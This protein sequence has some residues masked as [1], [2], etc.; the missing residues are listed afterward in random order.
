MSKCKPTSLTYSDKIATNICKS[1]SSFA[2]TKD[3]CHKAASP[4]SDR[5]IAPLTCDELKLMLL[6]PFLALP[7]FSTG[8]ET[9]KLEKKFAIKTTLTVGVDYSPIFFPGLP[10]QM[11]FTEID[12]LALAKFPS[13]AVVISSGSIRVEYIVRKRGDIY[14]IEPS[15]KSRNQPSELSVGSVN[16]QINTS[17]YG[18]CSGFAK[19]I[20]I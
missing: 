15:N 18:G 11:T 9:T 2:Y 10:S 20:I 8:M 17:A 7:F 14:Y 5:Y 12:Y 16:V 1:C 3:C 19:D 13:P 6:F 4:G